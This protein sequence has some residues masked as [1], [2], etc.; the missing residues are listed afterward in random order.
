MY[1]SLKYSTELD[2]D[3]RWLNVHLQIDCQTTAFQAFELLGFLGVVIY[4]IGIPVLTLAMLMR[5][6]A[7]IRGFGPSRVR[8]EFLV[9]SYRPE[10]L[11]GSVGRGVKDFLL[12]HLSILLPSSVR[13]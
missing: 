13:F 4:P 6:S 11:W 9:E 3:E 5:N 1:Y 2:E 7:D 10:Y 12:T 8:Y